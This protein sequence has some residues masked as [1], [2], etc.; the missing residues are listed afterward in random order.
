MQCPCHRA[1]ARFAPGVACPETVV[2]GSYMNASILQALV[3]DNRHAAVL[4]L[5][6]AGGGCDQQAGVAKGLNGDLP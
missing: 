3:Q 4:R 2:N 5:A 1:N 6:D